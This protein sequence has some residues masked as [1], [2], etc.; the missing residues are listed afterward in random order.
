[1]NN[2]AEKAWY[3]LDHAA[4]IFPP[5]SSKSDTKVFRFSCE[6]RE[7]VDGEMLQAALDRTIE[8]FPSFRYVLKHG[9]FWYYLEQSNIRPVVRVEDT[10]PCSTIYLNSK[11]LLF[12]VTWYGN[13]I[14]LE[15]Y[16]ALTDGTGALQFLKMLVLYYLKLIHSEIK[17]N[18]SGVDF[19]YD[20]SENQKMT[21]SF[22]EYYDRSKN[23]GDSRSPAAYQL[24]GAKETEWRLN[25]IEG[26]VSTKALLDKSREY[27]A[28]AT[29]FITALL[30]RAI[31]G[32][33][34]MNDRKKPVVINIPV[35]L[36]NYFE[37]KTARNFFSLIEIKYDFSNNK[38]SLEDIIN[39]TKKCFDERLNEE[40]L[41]ARLN[42]LLSF[43]HNFLIR[44]VPL[45]IKDLYM[46]IAYSL[47]RNE[48]TATVSNVG[49]V[50]MPEEAKPYIRL[51]DVFNSTKK[52][53][54]CICSYEDNMNIS[55]TSPFVNTD[56][57]RSFFRQ[58]S[59]L[60]IAVE[61]S[62]NNLKVNQGVKNR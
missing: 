35:N 33:M 46:S 10:P 5:T 42:K 58:L 13:R 61:I 45:A 9:M 44:L 51:F 8:D 16:H 41:Q 57:Q 22:N 25:I 62:A 52:L 34:G 1:M 38:D 54:I 11:A 19:D 32:E 59:K 17:G 55:F 27:G 2:P 6:L 24:K 47:A 30:I 3:K 31:Y 4:K 56:I 15:V 37:S 39:Y 48:F 18:I 20:A 12:E 36:R 23:T 29:V 53:Q 50:V 49:R 21:D 26:S 43:E 14:N 40:Y 28:T 60:G 7:A